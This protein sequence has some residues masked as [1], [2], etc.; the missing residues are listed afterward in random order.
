MAGGDAEEGVNEL[1][2]EIKGEADSMSS[3]DAVDG[4]QHRHRNVPKCG[5]CMNRQCLLL[6]ISRHLGAR[7]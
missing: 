3:S 1:T 6:A 7:N 4:S 5:R 2:I